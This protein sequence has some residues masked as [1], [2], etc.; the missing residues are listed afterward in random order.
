MIIP[1]DLYSFCV[2]KCS[3][4]IYW[5]YHCMRIRG[6]LLSVS[7]CF[8]HLNWFYIYNIF[9]CLNE[10]LTIRYIYICIFTANHTIYIYIYW[11]V[12][13]RNSSKNGWPSSVCRRIAVWR[14]GTRSGALLQGVRSDQRY[15]YQEWLRV[16]CKFNI[17]HVDYMSGNI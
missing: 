7:Y 12:P 2:S 4:S 15:S 11:K 17:I 13:F 10:E 6:A 8:N 3:L 5:Y 14:Q 16:C 1:F 9:S